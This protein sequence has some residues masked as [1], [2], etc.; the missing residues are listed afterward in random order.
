MAGAFLQVP[1]WVLFKCQ[2]T[3]LGLSVGRTLWHELS[4]QD[5]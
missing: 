5:R 1:R 3:A 4:D 2:M